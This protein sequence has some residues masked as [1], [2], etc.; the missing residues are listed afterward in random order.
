MLQLLLDNL[1]FA[2]EEDPFQVVVSP[3]NGTIFIID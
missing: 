1:E 2:R 3:D